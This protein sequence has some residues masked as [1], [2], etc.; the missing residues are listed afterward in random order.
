MRRRPGG[1]HHPGGRAAPLHAMRATAAAT[2][3]HATR[4]VSDGSHNSPTREQRRRRR[5]RPPFARAAAATTNLAGG[6]DSPLCDASREHTSTVAA[7]RTQRRH[8]HGGRRIVSSSTSSPLPAS[9]WWRV[10]PKTEPKKPNP[11]TSVF[12]FL[13]NR[14]VGGR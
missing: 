10:L 7:W 4:A 3:P 2:F 1:A 13:E 6:D 12:D 11:N 8:A 9:V 5:P 14:S